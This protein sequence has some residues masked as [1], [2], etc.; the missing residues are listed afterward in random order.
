[1]NV[2]KEIIKL[3]LKEEN[4]IQESFT[5]WHKGNGNEIK[6]YCEALKRKKEFFHLN[7]REKAED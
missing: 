3:L 5:I 7:P 2:L 4:K 6:S 1:M